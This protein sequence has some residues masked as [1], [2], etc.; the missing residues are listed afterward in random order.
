MYDRRLLY[1]GMARRKASPGGEAGS[2]QGLT[3]EV[4]VINYHHEFV[5][6]GY[7][8]PHP[9]RAVARA[10][11]PQGKANL[12]RVGSLLL[13]PTVH[14]LSQS[15]GLTAPP[16]QGSHWSVLR[17]RPLP[18]HIRPFGPPSPQGEGFFAPAGRKISCR[19][20][21]YFA[22]AFCGFYAFISCIYQWPRRGCRWI[23]DPR[24]PRRPPR[25]GA[26]GP[27]E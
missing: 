25:S 24:R 26:C 12:R 3:D 18:P 21:G 22:Y 27:S 17:R 6:C 7:L 16:T 11:F 2:P 20:G 1:A 14:P 9:S 8:R 19:G 5:R 10:T 4:E 15:C 13:R 23:S